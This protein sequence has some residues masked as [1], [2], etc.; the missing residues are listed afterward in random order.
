M[1]N[2]TLS[3]TR[4]WGLAELLPWWQLLRIPSAGGEFQMCEWG[5][6]VKLLGLKCYKSSCRRDEH[7]WQI[8]KCKRKTENFIS[9]RCPWEYFLF[10]L[11]IP[12]LVIIAYKQLVPGS[13]WITTCLYRFDSL[14]PWSDSVF[15]VFL[16]NW[17]IGLC[18][19]FV[20]YL[21]FGWC[22]LWLVSFTLKKACF[23]HTF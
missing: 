3:N 16:L 18:P 11:L 23:V 19:H 13:L 8:T 2:T 6:T 1:S 17:P 15:G 22:Y 21:Y 9:T 7:I 5:A 14:F 4:S 20:F 12:Q 10:L